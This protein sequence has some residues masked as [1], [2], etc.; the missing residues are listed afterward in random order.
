MKISSFQRVGI[1]T[2]SA[3]LA[4]SL[5]ACAAPRSDYPTGGYQQ[6]AY[7]APERGTEYGRV[8]NIYQLQGQSSG[9]TSGAGAVI[10]AVVGGVL[11]HQ[12]GGGSGRTLATAAGAVGGA[13]AGNAIEEH[14][15]GGGRASGYRV[16]IRLD[17]GG[18]R[19]YDVSSPGDLRVGDRVRMV[20]GQISRY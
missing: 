20:N 12:I 8:T 13:V 17:Q 10:G 14:N 4:A 9:R 7:S 19:D 11:G 2:A 6:G 16:V 1:V 15:S 5:A 18:Q 3:V